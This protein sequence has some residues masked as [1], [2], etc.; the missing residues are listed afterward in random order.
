M[1]AV[2]ELKNLSVSFDTKR[3]EVQAVRDVSFSLKKGE[4]LAVVGESGCG[5]TVMSQSVLKLLPGNAKIKS[6]QILVEGK[7]ITKYKE[8]EMRSLRGTTLAMVFQDPMMT[9]NPTIPVGVQ[10]TEA[11]LQHEK[12]SRQEAKKRAVEMLK[13]VGIEEAEQRYQLQPHYFSGGMRQRCMLAIALALKPKVLFADEPTTA[14]DVSVQAQIIN[15]FSHLKKEHNSAFLFVA[16]D[17]A[18]VRYLCN[19]VAVMHQGKIV[20]MGKTEEIFL[21]PKEEYT[22]KLLDAILVPDP[23]FERERRRK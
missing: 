21:N 3:G 18:L 8:K 6:G 17:L 5:K 23:I 10:I 20:E 2:L 11:I 13:L 14:L 15:L 9:L 19:K 1:E 7:D 16:H 12:I 22:K 4:I